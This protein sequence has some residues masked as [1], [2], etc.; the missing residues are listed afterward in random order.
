MGLPVDIG[1]MMTGKPQHE[2]YD[3]PDYDALW[4]CATELDLPIAFHILTA[5]DFAPEVAFR[6]FRG[7]VA[8]SFMNIIRGVQD[9]MGVFV[10]GGVFDRHPNLKVVVAE[11]DAGWVPH[12]MYRADHAVTHLELGKQKALSKISKHVSVLTQDEGL[13]NHYEAVRGRLK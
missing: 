7:Q 4:E 12:Y 10:F 3:H 11:A 13:P 9:V 1:M 2:D 5:N 6:A 8:N